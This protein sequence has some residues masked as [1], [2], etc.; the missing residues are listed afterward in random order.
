MPSYSYRA[1][2]ASG[3]VTEGRLDAGARGE[4]FAALEKLGLQPI[5]VSEQD[6]NARPESLLKI[7]WGGKKIPFSALENFTHQLSN[8]L[9]AGI[10]LSRALKISY[11]EASNAAAAAR[12]KELHDLVIDGMSLADA[13]ARF[14]ETFPKVYVAIVHSGET[15]GFLDLALS[16]I[17]EFQRRERDLKSRALSALIYPAVLGV[18]AAGVLV[19][20]MAFFIPRFKDIFLEFGAALPALTKMI[21][22]L[23][24]MIVRFGLIL[25]LAVAAGFYAAR[26]WLRSDRGRRA[27]ERWL[28]LTPIIGPQTARFAMARFL[29]MLGTLTG[30]GVPLI[31]SLRVA[32]ASL[33]NQILV[34][35]VEES[36]EQVQQ[37]SGLSASLRGCRLLFPGSVLEMVSVAE[38]TGRLDSE[39]VRLAESAEADLDRQLRTAVALVEPAMLFLMAGLIGTIVVGM[40]LPIL[41]LQDYIK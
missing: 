6:L 8:L 10:P 19:F 41:T 12:W 1:I 35:A 18:L 29:R 31:N 28:L 36:I 11:R 7:R 14:P 24:D 25:A 17:A 3:G 30:A 23:S 33:G 9:T 21:M 16:Q 4:A 27:Y 38:E 40:L 15:G 26:N 39:L 2:A 34:D 22:A 5:E 20:L 37:G 32:R 13:M